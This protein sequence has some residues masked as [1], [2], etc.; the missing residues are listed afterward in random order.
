MFRIVGAALQGEHSCAFYNVSNY[1]ENSVIVNLDSLV[2]SHKN[3]HSI[4]VISL[5][6]RCFCFNFEVISRKFVGRHFRCL[7]EE[8]LWN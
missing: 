3:R 5:I 4:I 1:L 8:M 7:M 2:C 6:S